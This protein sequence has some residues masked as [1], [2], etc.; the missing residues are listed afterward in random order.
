MNTTPPRNRGGRPAQVTRE[1][2][3]TAAIDLL[4]AQGLDALTMRALGAHLGVAAMSL[5]RH[6]PGRDAVL[7]AIVN[8]LVA[9]ALTGLDPGP[10]WTEAVTGFATAYRRM[11]LAHPH[12]VPLLAT[13][14]VD[15]ET[16]LPLL[17][18]VLGR[19]TAAGIA[20]DDALI[21]IQS[22]GVYVLG[23]ALAQV[24]TP[25]G[26]EEAGPPDPAARQYYDHWFTT[27]LNALVTGFQHQYGDPA[28]PARPTA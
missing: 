6:V 2:I 22:V 9:D 26:A 15:V 4:D 20:Q 16:A 11:L 21:T 1:Q 10:T 8:R 12:A 28:A 14:P 3:V 23:H 13:H 19:F 18:G 24:G 7:S 5:Y 27:G 25:P 17:R